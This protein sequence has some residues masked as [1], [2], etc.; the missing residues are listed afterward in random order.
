MT[1]DG[2]RYDAAIY[3]EGDF[4]ASIAYAQTLEKDYSSDAYKLL[5]N[6]C[7]QVATDVLMQGEYEQNNTSYKVML[8]K[9]RNSIIPNVAYSRMINFYNAEQTYNA[10]PNWS[11]WLYTSPERAALTY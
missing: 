3:F 11:K 2:N 5:R 9:A 6:N 1:I 10:A 7:M 8:S 4:G